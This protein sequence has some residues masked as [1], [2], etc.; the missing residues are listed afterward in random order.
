MSSL[1]QAGSA[2]P[3]F[4]GKLRLVNLLAKVGSRFGGGRSSFPVTN[5]VRFEVDLH[6]RIQRQMWAGCYEPHVRR[7]LSALLREGDVFLDVGA[8]IGF[9][10]GVAAARV[11]PQ[12][13][14]F[15]FE[16]DPSNY[17]KLAH[18]VSRLPWVKALNNA[19]WKESGRIVFE[20]SSHQG[21]LGW[22]TVT[23]VR[24]LG[25]GEHITVDA[26][27]L[28]DWS[29]RFPVDQVR[30]IKIDAEGSEVAIL[31]GSRKMIEKYRPL[32]IVEANDVVLRQAG[33]SS[34]ELATQL[35]QTGYA[36]HDLSWM[37][38]DRLV[39]GEAPRASEML[40]IPIEKIDA[41]LI[42]LKG[43]GFKLR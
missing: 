9:F 18:N 40:C 14:V 24:D 19:I 5:G 32:M 29:V 16:A 13:K 4:R 39:Q 17:A 30:A 12:G 15:A 27:S 3:P 36:L 38:L 28:D 1:Y 25:Q 37:K 7:C 22:G 43:A 21:E 6:D 41:T 31:A 10:T 33:T 8:H 23:A 42:T 11:G 34:A 2:I 26:V 35:T 20:R